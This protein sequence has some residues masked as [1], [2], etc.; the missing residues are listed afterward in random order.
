MITRNNFQSLGSATFSTFSRPLVTSVTMS[1]VLV[2]FASTFGV[3][4]SDTIAVK[5]YHN[6]D[7]QKS[8]ILAEN[9]GKSGVYCFTNLTNGKSYIGSS[10]DL[11][12]RMYDYYNVKYLST[13]TSMPICMALLKYG[14]SGFSLEILEYCARED[15][16]S[17]ENY[18]FALLEPEYNIAKHA[19]APMLGRNH[20]IATKA[21]ISL[22]R[23]GVFRSAETRK[24]ISDGLL[25]RIQSEETKRKIS[26]TKKGKKKKTSDETKKKISASLGLPLEVLNT[27]TGEMKTYSTGKEASIA[28]SCSSGTVS[29]YK[30]SGKLYKGIFII[31]KLG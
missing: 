5:V 19:S 24:Q 21:K 30:K 16:V 27:K 31:K 29:N 20:T 15:C 18:Y 8:Q 7:L 11:R 6:A 1:R 4:G 12:G 23:T 9:K 25:G 3:P 17:R 28:L 22:L 13:H 26:E 10:I 14:Y 2:R